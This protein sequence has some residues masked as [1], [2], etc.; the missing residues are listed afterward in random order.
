MISLHLV[1]LVPMSD[2]PQNPQVTVVALRGPDHLWDFSHQQNSHSFVLHFLHAG[3]AR[4]TFLCPPT[5]Q[6]RG[7]RTPESRP[8]FRWNP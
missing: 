8:A 5:E 1:N 4:L 2:S 3:A 6:T 7:W